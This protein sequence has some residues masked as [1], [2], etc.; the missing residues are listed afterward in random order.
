MGNSTMWKRIL[1]LSR[2][3]IRLNLT[4]SVEY[5]WLSTAI[6]ACD[7]DG[8]GGNASAIDWVSG[9][10]LNIDVIPRF[11]TACFFVSDRTLNNY[12][13]GG[14]LCWTCGPPYFL[15]LKSTP[16]TQR[17]NSCPCVTCHRQ[18]LRGRGSVCRGLIW[19]MVCI[20]EFITCMLLFQLLII[21]PLCIW[22]QHHVRWLFSWQAKMCIGT[23]IHE[24]VVREWVAEWHVERCVDEGNMDD[25]ACVVINSLSPDLLISYR[26]VDGSLAD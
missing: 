2:D 12:W 16:L 22:S 21:V 11:L 7:H 4:W 1:A 6:F 19:F 23:F 14:M 20:G 24:K 26:S 18:A 17:G 9:K 10:F 3:R 15:W 8:K 5:W 13:G 25:F